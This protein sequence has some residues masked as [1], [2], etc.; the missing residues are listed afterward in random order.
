MPRSPETDFVT[1][2][3]VNDPQQSGDRKNQAA[4]RAPLSPDRAADVAFKRVD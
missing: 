1:R 2:F 3:T 4:R